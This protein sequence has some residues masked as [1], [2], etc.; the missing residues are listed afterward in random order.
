MVVSTIFFNKFCT[1]TASPLLD[2]YEA[3]THKQ[4]SVHGGLPQVLMD[5]REGFST[6][7][8]FNKYKSQQTDQSGN[9]RDRW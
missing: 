5:N 7:A 2:Y 3:S 1:T 6:C 4:K 8:I 9:P